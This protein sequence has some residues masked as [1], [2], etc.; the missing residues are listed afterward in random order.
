MASELVVF[1]HEGET[2]EES[3][4]MNAAYN[5]VKEKEVEIAK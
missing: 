5:R 4:A 3:D 2:S 1:T